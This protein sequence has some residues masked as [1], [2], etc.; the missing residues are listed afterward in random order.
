[1]QALPATTIVLLLI[2][3]AVVGFPLTVLGG[4]LGRKNAGVCLQ[5]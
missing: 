2:I 5:F 4:L 3:W 1:M